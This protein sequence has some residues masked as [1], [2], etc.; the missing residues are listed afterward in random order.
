MREYLCNINPDIKKR[1]DVLGLDFTTSVINP[2]TSNEMFIN[3][4]DKDIPKWDINKHFFEQPLSTIQFWEEEYRKIC[5]GINVFGYSISPFLY[6]HLN[7]FKLAY[8]AKG[9]KGAKQPLFRDNE[10]FFD[11]TLLEAE[12]HGRVGAFFYGSR[13]WSKS[14]N[15]SSKTVHSLLTIP[16]AQG[17]IQ[18]YSEVPDLKAIIDYIGD[19]VENLEPALRVNAN[20]MDLKEGAVLGLKGKKVQDR[21][22]F[23]RL[24]VVNLEGGNTKKGGQKTAGSTPD[25]FIFDEAL[26]E[27]EEVYL[28]NEKWIPIKAVK[29]G[30][31]IC[32]ARS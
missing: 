21:Y 26:H 23:S 2:A 8:G 25:V 31:R 10:Y 15:A 7:H 29:I 14:V 16:K 30:D 13:R 20:N 5:N 28:E 27:D 11:Q 18:G 4:K 1:T 32:N 12:N 6:W 17:T 3:M 22:D 19:A 9:D 24:S